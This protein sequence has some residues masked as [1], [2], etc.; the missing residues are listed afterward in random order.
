MAVVLS[1]KYAANF[2]N[3]GVTVTEKGTEVL[4]IPATSPFHDKFEAEYND[5][6]FSDTVIAKYI[7]IMED[8]NDNI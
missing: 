2:T 1:G 4:N 7:K 8:R 6:G 3:G 5:S